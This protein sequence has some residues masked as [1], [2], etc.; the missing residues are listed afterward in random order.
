MDSQRHQRIYQSNFNRI[1]KPNPMIIDMHAHA[2][3]EGFLSDLCTHPIAG[4]SCRKDGHGGFLIRR[5][6]DDAPRSLDKNLHD[7]PHRLDSLTAAIRTTAGTDF[8]AGR[9]RPE[10]MGAC[11]SQGAGQDRGRS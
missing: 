10:G 5:P 2:L 1:G 7:L 6:I 8:L 9:R 4:M 3:A 11:D